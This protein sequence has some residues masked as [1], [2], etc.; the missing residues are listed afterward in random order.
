MECDC[1]T[2]PR[3]IR[4]EG[5]REGGRQKEE[6]EREGGRGKEEG[7]LEGGRKG[8]KCIKIN[9]HHQTSANTQS[10]YSL[11]NQMDGSG[12]QPRTDHTL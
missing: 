6:G 10:I 3:H 12:K 2:W 11:P 9:F 7:E 8:E 4:R 1:Q 5:G